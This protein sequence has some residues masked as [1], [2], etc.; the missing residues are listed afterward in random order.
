MFSQ[1]QNLHHVLDTVLTKNKYVFDTFE[2]AEKAPSGM[3]FETFIRLFH[4]GSKKFLFRKD[5]ERELEK[6]LT[7]KYDGRLD[8]PKGE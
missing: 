4:D 2:S 1:L 5:V 3:K 8:V 7:K 6:A